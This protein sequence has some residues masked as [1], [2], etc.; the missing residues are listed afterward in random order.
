MAGKG[1]DWQAAIAWSCKHY[2]REKL[3]R[4]EQHF[5]PYAQIGG[6]DK[7]GF[8]KARR[9]ADAPPDFSGLIYG[10]PGYS[11]LFDAKECRGDRW[12]F[13][14]LKKHQAMD[15]TAELNG[16]VP[17]ILLRFGGYHGPCGLASWDKVRPLWWAWEKSGGRQNVSSLRLEDCAPVPMVEIKWGTKTLR[18]PD[19]LPAAQAEGRRLYE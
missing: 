11:V 9:I 1:M 12:G 7:R 2:R 6:Q 3:A 14:L 19:W 18:V 16:G 15:L 5:E 13:E 4:V 8:F 10:R 17:F